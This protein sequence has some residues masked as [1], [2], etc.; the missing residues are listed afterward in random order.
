MIRRAPFA[1]LLLF[2]LISPA[3]VMAAADVQNL[4]G[5]YQTTLQSGIVMPAG[6][7]KEECTQEWS[8][9]ESTCVDDA[10]FTNH[11]LLFQQSDA[12]HFQTVLWF[13]NGHMCSLSGVASPHPKGWMYEEYTDIA[14]CKFFIREDNGVILL[15]AD[16]E[17]NCRAYCGARGYFSGIQFPLS[18]KKQD[19]ESLEAYNCITLF[20]EPADH[21]PQDSK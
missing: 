6:T 16:R 17:H 15:E 5:H 3:L 1:A 7:P 10:E 8:G 19:I 4:S 14:D 13:F 2:M 20:E 21:C 9:L 11:L 12:L 18:A